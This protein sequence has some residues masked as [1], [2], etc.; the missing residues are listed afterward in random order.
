MNQISDIVSFHLDCQTR[1]DVRLTMGSSNY[2]PNHAYNNVAN[3]E[4]SLEA[5][6][7]FKRE[8]RFCN[9]AAYDTGANGGH[10]RELPV[11]EFGYSNNGYCQK[12]SSYFDMDNNAIVL[13][14]GEVRP[15]AN[16]NTEFR[17]YDSH[18]GDSSNGHNFND[19]TTDYYNNNQRNLQIFNNDH[20]MYSNNSREE[21]FK[22]RRKKEI[23]ERSEKNRYPRSIMSHPRKYAKI[24]TPILFSAIVAKYS[25]HF[26]KLKPNYPSS[27]TSNSQDSDFKNEVSN[28]DPAPFLNNKISNLNS[29]ELPLNIYADPNKKKIFNPASNHLDLKPQTGTLKTRKKDSIPSSFNPDFKCSHPGCLKTYSKISHLRAHSRVH[30]GEKPYSCDW[31]GC[32]W[33]FA[34]SDELTRHFRKHTGDKPFKCSVCLRAFARSDHLSLHIKRHKF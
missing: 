9:T 20:C 18:N 16:A 32:G 11:T 8:R 3:F 26:Q 33:K 14:T 4:D 2:P 6:D 29:S 12:K 23:V 5:I 1:F 34:R 30:T 17:L 22:P 7:T 21:I 28:I 15:V 24:N 25:Y 31:N 13:E 10:D 27:R 19:Q